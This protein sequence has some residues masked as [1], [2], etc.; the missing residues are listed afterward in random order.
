LFFSLK[1]K[2]QNR[3]QNLNLLKH[4]NKYAF[5]FTHLKQKNEAKRSKFVFLFRFQKRNG[6]RFVFFGF[7]GKWFHHVQNNT[8][9]DH[10]PPASQAGR[11]VGPAL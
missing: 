6:S 4:A 8:L 3:K 1:S 5:W 7:G 9:L 10:S 2:K 11:R